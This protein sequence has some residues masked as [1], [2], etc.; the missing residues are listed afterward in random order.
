M[1][2]IRADLLETVEDGWRDE[3]IR[4]PFHSPVLE[5][6]SISISQLLSI[7]QPPGLILIR[8]WQDFPSTFEQALT[9]NDL[10]YSQSCHAAW[11]GAS[12]CATDPEESGGPI[13]SEAQIF[14]NKGER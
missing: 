10:L 1:R 7:E 14:Y 5:I 13:A 2:K 12:R 3:V 11:R 9:E 8:H 4:G 6:C